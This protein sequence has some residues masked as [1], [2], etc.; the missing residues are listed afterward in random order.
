MSADQINIAAGGDL[1]MTGSA[2]FGAGN[3]QLSAAGNVSI[4]AAT[5]TETTYTESTKRSSG[6]TSGGGFGI[7]I[8]SSSQKSQAWLDATRQSQGMSL[9]GS[10][11]GSVS[12]SAGKDNNI[13]GTILG[14]SAA[15]VDRPLPAGTSETAVPGQC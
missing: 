13:S 2:V 9:V 5:N 10:E 12:V 3:T 6:I 15:A 11:F 4:Q 14:F 7:H 1:S 8:G